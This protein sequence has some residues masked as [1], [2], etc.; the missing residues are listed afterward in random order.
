MQDED[1]FGGITLH[2]LSYGDSTRRSPS[3][4]QVDPDDPYG[5]GLA[6]EAGGQSPLKKTITSKDVLEQWKDQ[7]K[8]VPG[9]LEGL[10]H[11]A[12]GAATFVPSGILGLGTIA[13]GKAQDW[14]ARELVKSKGDKMSPEEIAKQE[15]LY[16]TPEDIDKAA[17]TS[18]AIFSQWIPEPQSESAKKIIAGTNEIIEKALFWAPSVEKYFDDKGQPNLGSSMRFVL[19]LAAFKAAHVGGK[20]I[21][22][23]VKG[24]NRKFKD[25]KTP[26]DVK[27]DIDALKKYLDPKDPELVKEQRAYYND[28]AVMERNMKAAKDAEITKEWVTRQRA[29]QAKLRKGIPVEK[30]K[31]EP[32]PEPLVYSEKPLSTGDPART[33]IEQQR[34]KE[35]LIKK[36]KLKKHESIDNIFAP[37]MNKR[38]SITVPNLKKFTEKVDP[39]IR[40]HIRRIGKAAEKSGMPLDLFLKNQGM[41]DNQIKA[42]EERPL[43]SA[44]TKDDV[45][46]AKDPLVMSEGD[47]NVNVSSSKKTKPSIEVGQKT[48]DQL[49]AAPNVSTAS[50]AKTFTPTLHKIRKFGIPVLK[51]LWHK[52]NKI[53]VARL[54]DLDILKKTILNLDKEYP[55]IKLRQEVYL[56]MMSQ[57]TLGRKAIEKSGY[58]PI[59]KPIAYDGMIKVLNEQFGDLV[60]R[61]NE[62]RIARGEKPIRVMKDYLPMIAQEN[63]YHQ[64]RTLKILNIVI[65]LLLL[66]LQTYV[67][68]REGNFEQAFD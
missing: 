40:D 13:L 18:R 45:S 2:G 17:D 48:L 5:T 1:P 25:G 16:M 4:Q 33:A 58:K 9:G 21:V 15:S 32:K 30:A 59:D 49:K 63:F 35:G 34:F 51:D 12:Y 41:T 66:M 64:L 53:E 22:R 47:T 3:E 67:I 42:K 52:A 6:V 54:K 28:K 44:L 55:D 68:Q 37:L 19:E 38:G 7:W 24:I 27:S 8:K 11:L 50:L 20:K 31:L 14:S 43:A 29:L 23:K 46:P 60:Q 39:T 61:I 56:K 62:A 36:F 57:N 10:A 26:E 65:L